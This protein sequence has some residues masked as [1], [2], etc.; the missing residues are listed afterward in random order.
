M[1]KAIALVHSV[2][3]DSLTPNRQERTFLLIGIFTF[4]FMLLLTSVSHAATACSIEAAPQYGETIVANCT[5]NITSGTCF[6]QVAYAGSTIEII[7]KDAFAYPDGASPLVGGAVAFPVVLGGKYEVGRAY[8]LTAV[9]SGQN[10]TYESAPVGFTLSNRRPLNFMPNELM[11]VR[12][13]FVFIGA[14]FL[15]FL[16]VVVGI[17]LAFYVM[18]TGGVL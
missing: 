5:S 10:Q 13:N 14:G 18:R 3:K 1:K 2:I 8:N 9:C 6:A 17:G 7:P 4:I 12:D 15:L 11:W 16:L